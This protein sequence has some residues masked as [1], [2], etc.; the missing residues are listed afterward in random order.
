MDK[1]ANYTVAITGA[2]G[3]IYGIRLIEELLKSGCH[4]NL[5]ISET[6]KDVLLHETGI[7][8]HGTEEEA[9]KKALKYF[10][11]K[12]SITFFDNSNLF[13]SVSS[14][15][16]KTDG[17]I[18]APCSMGALGRI[19]SGHSQKLIERT[20]DV[21]L[22]E[23]RRLIIVPRETPLNQVHLENMLKLSKMNVDI[24]PAMPAF[25]QR[26]KTMDD[27]VNFVVGKVLDLLRIEHNLFERWKS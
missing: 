12:G 23:K 9:S 3:S 7:D 16:H 10:K 21:M 26:P 1:I 27:L 2:S 5:V 19:A 22:K 24:V 8:L 25:Y 17:M 4:I 14:G 6:G 11:K 18:I 15:S 20:A 13:A